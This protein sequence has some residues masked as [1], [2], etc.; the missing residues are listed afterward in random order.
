L[1]LGFDP[2]DHGEVREHRFAQVT[3]VRCHPVDLTAKRVPARFDPPS[4]QVHRLIRYEFHVIWRIAEQL[5]DVGYTAG[6][7][8][9]NDMQ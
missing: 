3:P 2:A 6:Q 1:D 9:F 7:F 4:G 5:F 8:S